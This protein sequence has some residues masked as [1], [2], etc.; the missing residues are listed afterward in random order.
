MESGRYVTQTSVLQF[1]HWSTK[2]Q[3]NSLVSSFDFNLTHYKINQAYDISTEHTPTH[4]LKG[5]QEECFAKAL[6]YF[7]LLHRLPRIQKL[8]LKTALRM[9]AFLP[10]PLQERLDR[11]RAQ[12]GER[13]R[14][15]PARGLVLSIMCGRAL[16]LVHVCSA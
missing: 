4:Y 3:L 10:L 12:S 9:R 1:L 7:S 5:L 16:G 8:L 2:N 14:M 11:S 15:H 13:A 6:P